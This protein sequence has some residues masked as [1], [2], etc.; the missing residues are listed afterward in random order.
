MAGKVGFK[1]TS[2]STG[3]VPG[4]LAR[5]N[6]PVLL[7]RE[8]QKNV[9]E[10]HIR[11]K[12]RKKAFAILRSS[13]Y[14][15]DDVKYY[16]PARARQLAPQLFGLLVGVLLFFAAVYTFESRV[17]TVEVTGSG[18]Y[19]ER[20]IRAILQEEGVGGFS[21]MP[22]DTAVL[23]ARVLALP[24]VE[25]CTFK[26]AGGILTVEVRVS[27]NAQPIAGMPLIAP[28]S[29]TVIGLT[30]VRGT[31]LVSVGDSVREGDTVVDVYTLAGEQKIPSLVIAAVTVEREI[32]LEYALPEDRAKAQALLDF[33]PLKNL[34]IEK[35]KQGCK[36]SGVMTK[37]ASVNLA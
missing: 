26:R 34:H 16:G 11:A 8:V 37:T 7:C 22:R 23:T 6:I 5:E 13:C 24:R 3:R 17:L 15:I 27:E 25:F 9:L 1:V 14:H 2:L 20:E 29:G 28:V 32:C 35:T 12:D 21:P 33:G 31:P 19:Y 30:V 4:K 18:A 36:V 10:V